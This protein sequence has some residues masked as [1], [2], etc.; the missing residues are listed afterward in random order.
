MTTDAP[1]PDDRVVICLERHGDDW[2]ARAYR[3]RGL[4]SGQTTI[5]TAAA[6]SPGEVLED[7]AL[8]LDR[9]EADRVRAAAAELRADL[10]A[11]RTQRELEA[12]VAAVVGVLEHAS[13]TGPG[14]LEPAV[15][16]LALKWTPG[17]IVNRA[18]PTQGD[19]DAIARVERALEQARADGAAQSRRVAGVGG[20]LWSI[21][22]A[23]REEAG[24]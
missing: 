1:K 8:A 14:E 12:D 17:T 6:E 15:I 4:L 23:A 20:L 11:T 9:L 10:T 7:L 16:A 13:R 24:R 2:A 5:A 19:L 21:H 22:P 18:R 3:E